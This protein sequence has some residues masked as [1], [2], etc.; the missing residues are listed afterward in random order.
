MMNLSDA[1]ISGSALTLWLT[2]LSASGKSTLAQGLAERLLSRGLHCK[3]IDGDELRR[4]LCAD[5]GF[6][7]AD[8][9]ENIRRVAEICRILNS[10]GVIAIAA[11]I[12]PY[13]DD[14]EL[15]RKIVGDAAFRE[16]WIAASLEACEA[17]D[18]KGLYRKARA[19]KIA[20]FT[21]ISDPY[22]PPL[23]PHLALDTHQLTVP[24]CVARLDALLY[25]ENS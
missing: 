14:R 1:L 9:R 12:S 11:L 5:L 24:E 23:V 16:V 22:E 8:R 19:G 25:Q 3:V 21:G 4:G 6:S 7:R 17:R 20:T 18:P 15:A 10:A 2:G 13:R